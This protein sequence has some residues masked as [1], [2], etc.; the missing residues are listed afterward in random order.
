MAGTGTDVA[1]GGCVETGAGGR[2][3]VGA[4]VMD[5]GNAVEEA[6]GADM[7]VVGVPVIGKAADTRL[8][9]LGLRR[10]L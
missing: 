4:A 6:E 7:L 1:G 2:E 9:G 10:R 5:A 8:L 3:G